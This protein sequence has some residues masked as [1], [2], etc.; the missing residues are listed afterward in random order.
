MTKEE[1][2][3][4]IIKNREYVK[5]RTDDELR[6]ELESLKPYRV[7]VY[8]W[9]KNSLRLIAVFAEFSKRNLKE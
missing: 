2:D 8:D 7:S 1:M 5:Q 9:H 3:E 6:S 4:L